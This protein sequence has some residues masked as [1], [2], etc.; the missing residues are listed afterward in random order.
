MINSWLVLSV[1]FLSGCPFFS[2]CFNQKKKKKKKKKNYNSVHHNLVFVLFFFF[3][4]PLSLLLFSIFGYSVIEHLAC[5]FSSSLL[6]LP[7]LS[8]KGISLRKPYSRI[9]FLSTICFGISSVRLSVTTL[10]PVA[11]VVNTFRCQQFFFPPRVILSKIVD[12]L[13]LLGVGIV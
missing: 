13:T 1:F 6:F 3:L 7:F 5:F 11:N 4:P 8:D 10:F 2:H 9:L 12:I